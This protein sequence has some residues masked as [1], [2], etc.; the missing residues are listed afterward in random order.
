MLSIFN[1]PII[2]SLTHKLSF[3]FAILYMVAFGLNFSTT[4]MFQYLFLSIIVVFGI[5]GIGYFFNDLTDIELDRKAGKRNMFLLLNK[6]TI[7]LLALG[8]VFFAILPWLVFPFTSISLLFMLVEISLFILYSFKP[9]RLKERGWAGLITDALYAHVVPAMFAVYT[10]TLVKTPTIQLAYF[11]FTGI[12]WVFLTGTRNILKHQIEDYDN[13]KRSSTKTLMQS[14][15]INRVQKN[16]VV[17]FIPMEIAL[18]L[19][20]IYGFDHNYLLIIGL[21]LIYSALYLYKRNKDIRIKSKIN[22]K[23]LFN[24]LAERILNE[25]YERWLGLLLI[26]VAIIYTKDASYLALLFFHIIL[27]HRILLPR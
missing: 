1:H 3:I 22:I 11:H 21:F 17:L 23:A 19:I 26:L 14:L 20:T 7:A 9:L 25:F 5:G 2:L 12:L 4:E 15:N 6:W 10:F 16:V 18:F 27:F 24:F 13:D 8:I